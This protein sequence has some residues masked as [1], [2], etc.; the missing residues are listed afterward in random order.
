MRIKISENSNKKKSTGFSKYVNFSDIPVHHFVNY[1][2][3]MQFIKKTIIN[4]GW[5]NRT[6]IIYKYFKKNKNLF[7][8]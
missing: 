1:E 2:Y 8:N 3:F 6:E 7:V 4:S 5:K